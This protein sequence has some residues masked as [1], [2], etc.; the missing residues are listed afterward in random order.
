MST[1]ILHILASTANGFSCNIMQ[2][3]YSLS[4]FQHFQSFVQIAN[5]LSKHSPIHS[6]D[7]IKAHIIKTKS[8]DTNDSREVSSHLY[9]YYSA[10]N[11]HFLKCPAALYT[12][13][14]TLSWERLT[15][16]NIMLQSLK[17]MSGFGAPSSLFCGNKS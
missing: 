8:K 14:Y 7:N 10:H 6:N 5:C 3:N 9:F 17:N 13:Q 16:P 12:K 1:Y 2:A 4:R 11:G 15:C